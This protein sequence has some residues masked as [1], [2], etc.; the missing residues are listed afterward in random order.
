MDAYS[1]SPPDRQI[2]A[3]NELYDLETDIG[4]TN[5]IYDQHPEIVDELETKLNICRQDLGDHI[6]GVEGQN[7]RPVGRV[8]NPQTLTH[9]DP[10]H[11]YIMAMYDL[12][13]RG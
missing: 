5:N 7:L 3:I 13:D 2:V 8:D 4:E 10:D 6:T 11:P 9:Y 1:F 12:K